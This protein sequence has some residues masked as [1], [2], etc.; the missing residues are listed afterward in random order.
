MNVYIKR[1]P[2]TIQ[3]N[4]PITI[5]KIKNYLFKRI[6]SLYLHLKMD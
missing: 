2:K 1:Q 3:E 4:S 5:K 6:F